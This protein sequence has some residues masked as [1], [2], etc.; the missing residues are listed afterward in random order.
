VGNLQFYVQ[1]I[2]IH[3]QLFFYL[4][5]REKKIKK[6]S[7]MKKFICVFF[8]FTLSFALFSQN[9]DIAL[10]HSINSGN[11]V[12]WT[13]TNKIFSQSVTPFTIAVPSTIFLYGAFNNY[14]SANRNSI[15]MGA[16]LLGAAILTVGMKYSFNRPRPFVT[17]PDLVTKNS[18]AGSP[19]FPSGHTSMAFALATSLSLE[20]PKWY[21]IAPSFLWAGAVGY[22][23]M[24]LGV[25]YPSDVLVGALIG[26]GSSFLVWKIDKRRM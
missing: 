23:R 13:Q 8:A 11:S 18:G 5:H 15:V 24:E 7:Q 20:Y 14:S 2:P 6:F 1:F 26:M 21:V 4:H 16:G 17:Y 9:I 25:H 22:S 3:Q 10:L 19:S 12:S